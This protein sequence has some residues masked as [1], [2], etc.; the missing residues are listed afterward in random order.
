M[1]SRL[2]SHWKGLMRSKGYYWLATRPL[3]MGTWSTAGTILSIDYA[4]VIGEE[5]EEEEEEGENNDADD[6]H[7]A[8]KPKSSETE[9]AGG[10]NG[11]DDNGG[12]QKIVL[13]GSFTA[14]EKIKIRQDL[15][16][17][18]L[19]DE[20]MKLFTA[21]N[22]SEFEDPWEVWPPVDESDDEHDKDD[23]NDCET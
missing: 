1:G 16:S 23:C 20:E 12:R 7:K 13:I 11:A 8:K 2:S 18:L 21:G 3:Q 22:L 17:C 4:G 6:Q 10:E 14:E 15:D 5:E 19:N 9:V